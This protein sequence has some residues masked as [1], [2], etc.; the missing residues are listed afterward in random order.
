MVTRSKPGNHASC[1]A[2]SEK[3]HKLVDPQVSL[4]SLFLKNAIAEYFVSS[5]L[6]HL[7]KQTYNQNL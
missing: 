5:K 6:L 3:P 7:V 2:L 4:Y 1:G